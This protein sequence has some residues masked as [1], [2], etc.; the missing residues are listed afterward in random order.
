MSSATLFWQIHGGVMDVSAKP[1]GRDLPRGVRDYVGEALAKNWQ[2]V[3]PSPEREPK[4]LLVMAGNPLRRVRSA[5]RLLEVLWPKL[6]LVVVTD[7]RMSSTAR[8]ADYV[9][10]VAASYEKPNA[11]SFIN[12][13]LLVHAA[14]AATAPA[15]GAKDEWEIACRLAE[16]IAERAKAR[17]VAPVTG[18]RGQE[19][20]LDR[21]YEVISREGEFRAGDAEKFA[22]GLIERSTN[23]DTAS[24][25]EA[26][27]RGFA[28]VTGLGR[29]LMNASSA[30]DWAPGE[31]VTP[32]LWHVRDKKPWP[33]LSGRVQFYIDHDWYLELGEAL[34]SYKEP[35]K[36]GGDHPLQMTGGHTRWSI[37]SLQRADAMLLRLQRGEPVLW[38]AAEDARARGI[39]DWDRVEVSNDVGRFRVRVK[40]SPAIRPGQV[41]MYHAWEDYQFEGGMGHR[42]V[43]AT[44]LNPLS[45]VGD[46]P[47]IGPTFGA[48]HPGMNDRDTRVEIRRV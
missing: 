26:A 10:P 11:S 41:V 39:A 37:H 40:V 24:F 20:R 43:L 16:K 6:D 8:F 38:V 48:R 32:F 7:I 22:R 46:Y 47:Y 15:G 13:F 28:R 14:R 30:T 1:W 33:T 29:G 4:A 25:D 5:H 2:L 17:G 36:A 42:N 34:P 9:L 35:P 12:Q 44:P 31:P 3:E 27:E 18:R 45:L 21:A 23:L 19:L